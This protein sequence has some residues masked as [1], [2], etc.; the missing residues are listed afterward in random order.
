MSQFKDIIAIG[1]DKNGEADF[2]VTASIAEL[3]VDRM[4]NL[5]SMIVV[6]IGTAEDMWRREQAG[7]N[8]AKSGGTVVNI[9]TVKPHD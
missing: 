3:S 6:A 7:R 4:N 9:T 2:R 1:F 8:I 5:R